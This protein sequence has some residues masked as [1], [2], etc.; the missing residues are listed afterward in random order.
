LTSFCFCFWA[1]LSS[2]RVARSP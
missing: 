1:A 2:I